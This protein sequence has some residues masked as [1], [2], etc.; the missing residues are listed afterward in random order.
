MASCRSSHSSH[1]TYVEL[2]ESEFL[3]HSIEEKQLVGLSASQ[4]TYF[5][6]SYSYIL[7]TRGFSLT[8]DVNGASDHCV[9]FDPMFVTQ[10]SC[11]PSYE[12]SQLNSRG[13]TGSIELPSRL[14]LSLSTPCTS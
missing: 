2:A 13:T 11:C 12:A 14:C 1:W 10:H 5:L 6:E 8:V 7:M 9:K 4:K 3:E